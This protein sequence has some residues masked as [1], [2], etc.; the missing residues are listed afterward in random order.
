MK[1]LYNIGNTCYINAVLQIFLMNDE[2]VINLMNSNLLKNSLL[3][4]LLELI[5]NDK[6]KANP[7]EFIN[8]LQKRLKRNLRIQSDSQE[9]LLSIIEQFKLE[10]ESLIN[11]FFGGK[12]KTCFTCT[13]CGNKRNKI[14]DFISI[15]LHSLGSKCIKKAIQ[16]YIKTEYF[17]DIFCETCKCNK[18]TRKKIKIF[19]YPKILI[20]QLVRFT[21]KNIIKH[22]N[23]ITF[24]KKNKKYIFQGIVNH[25]GRS[26]D[27]G[28]Y[29]Y[30]DSIIILDDSTKYKI[31][32]LAPKDH[33]LLI[34]KLKVN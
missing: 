17:E 2:F 3:I 9:I 20:F 31:S 12:T 1:L 16:E 5:I 10:N 29:T 22:V 13:S 27:S 4:K 6:E 18:R 14:E 33:Y 23:S 28:H 11:T 8:L 34:Y 19:F 7:I 15:P 24:S 30:T 25:I 32:K 26:L 21:C